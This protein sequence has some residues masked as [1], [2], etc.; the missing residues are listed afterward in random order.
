M[1]AVFRR[2][3]WRHFAAHKAR[4]CFTIGGI[5]LGVATVV[6]M[7]VMHASVARS[8]ET[9]VERIAGRA[10]LEITNGEVG[11]PE[12]LLKEVEGVPGVGAAAPS[13]QGFV[14]VRDFPGERLYVFGV[15]LLADQKLRDY[16]FGS[17]EATVEDPLVFLAQPDSVAVSTQFLE[18]TRLALEDPLTI[19]APSGVR[20][21]T[22]RASLDTRR[23]PASLFGGRLAVMDAFAAQRLFELDR[24]FSQIDVGLAENAD[25]DSVKAAL[26]RV[27]GARGIVERPRTRG[28]TLEKM[29]TANRYAMTIAAMLGVI[30]GLYLIFNTVMVS[31]AQR[32][33]EIGT[34]RALGMRRRQVLAFILLESIALGAAGCLAGVPLGYALARGMAGAF[35]VNISTMYMP[36]EAPDIRLDVASVSWGVVLGLFGAIIAAIIPAREA[37]R[38]HPLEALRP[39]SRRTMRASTYRRAAAAGS[40]IVAFALLVWT[41]RA[42]MPLSKNVSG[43]LVILGLLVGISL[44]V[45]A[46][47]RAFALR[48]E[49]LLSRLLGPVGSLA[50]RSIVGHIGRVAITCSAFLV[51]LA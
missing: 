4:T 50:T 5:A 9:T 44:V 6:G 2:L 35:A 39:S 34:L 36:V 13:V 43:A 29:L 25:L 26:E 20:R 41:A 31:V 24:R 32:G 1:I 51:S 22:I 40:V 28:E 37:V 46:A 33:R 17:G 19:L 38:I 27:V 16:Q 10:A 23:G 7:R 18:R 11:V 21:L 3:G 47:V 30:V 45:P 15:D 12:E 42:V 8:Y 14:S 49:P 48:C